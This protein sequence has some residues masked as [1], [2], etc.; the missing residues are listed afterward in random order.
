[1]STQ[2][3]PFYSA[4]VL[5]VT[6]FAMSAAAPSAAWAQDKSWTTVGSAGTV[7]EDS[8]SAVTY[9]NGTARVRDTAPAGTAAVIRYNVVAVDGLFVGDGI[10]LTS[11][12]FDHEDAD[13]VLVQLK[14]LNRA[15]GLVTTLVTLDSNS[16]PPT[17]G[18]Q[19]QTACNSDAQFDFSANAYYVEVKLTKNVA[20]R[21]GSGLA[22]V[23]EPAVSM[24]QIVGACG[25]VPR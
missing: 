8:L 18:F 20:R 1:M 9:T 4:V 12:F 13:Q 21:H 14:G 16:Y 11:R 24:V 6:V 19:V 15:T 2:R 3:A 7:D 5:V 25:D 22:V 17:N 23:T 10:S